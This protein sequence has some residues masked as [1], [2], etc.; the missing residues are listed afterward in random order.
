MEGIKPIGRENRA[1]H[2]A[3]RDFQL[4]RSQNVPP[5]KEILGC[6]CV[7]LNPDVRALRS[8]RDTHRRCLRLGGDF[9]SFEWPGFEVGDLLVDQHSRRFA[10][11]GRPF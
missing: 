6:D 9:D 3:L 8:L 7:A 5:T 10:Y 1:E 4:E 2:V 11:V